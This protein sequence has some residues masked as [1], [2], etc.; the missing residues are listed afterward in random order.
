LKNFYIHG[1][2]M[3]RFLFVIGLLLVSVSLSAAHVRHRIN[4]N[5]QDVTIKTEKV[6][7]NVYVLFGAGGNIGVTAG[8]DGILIIDDQFI[9]VAEKIKVALKDLGSDTPRFVFN[10]HW[11]G[12]HTGG[13]PIFGQNSIIVAHENVRKRLSTDS[14]TRGR[15]FKALAPVGLPMITYGQ[16]LSIHFNGEE[17]RAVHYP[18]GHT[19]G[20]TVIFFTGS[21]V[22][23]LGD[24]FF[25]GKFPFV[26]L[27]S[28]GSVAG[29]IQNIDTLIKQIPADAK[30]IP[31]HGAVSS[32]NDLKIYHQTL[33]E[34]TN[35]V[36]RQM[37]EKKSLDEIKKAGLPDKFKDWGTGFIKTDAWIETI[38]KD[39]SVNMSGSKNSK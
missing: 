6:A 2:K 31:G 33:V 36:R 21:N 35:I 28:G 30:I 8:K 7:G 5:K 14:V 18:N 9:N 22:V 39:Y 15:Q 16:G 38:Y 27:E 20:D 10:T 29:L 17:I 32:L 23:H 11:H 24:D 4:A 1:G 3:R 34:T 12:D 26:D 19:D 37:S 13:N 25:V